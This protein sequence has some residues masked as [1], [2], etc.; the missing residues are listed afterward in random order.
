MNWDFQF[1]YSLVNISIRINHSRKLPQ[2]L[3]IGFKFGEDAG[4]YLVV[5]LQAPNHSSVRAETCGLALSRWRNISL[6]FRLI[7]N[8]SRYFSKISWYFSPLIVPSIIANS[9]SPLYLRQ[10]HI[11]AEGPPIALREY[12]TSLYLIQPIGN[13]TRRGHLNWTFFQQERLHLSTL[14]LFPDILTEK[15]IRFCLRTIDSDGL[16]LIFLHFKFVSITII[17]LTVHLST[18]S[19]DEPFIELAVIFFPF[20][21]IDIFCSWIKLFWTS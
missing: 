7:I 16:R 5:V 1:I 20:A 10:P 18:L 11:T 13:Y 6:V 14:H 2:R 8:G 21:I 12:V 4:Q 17:Q 9:D 3:S 15:T 19:A